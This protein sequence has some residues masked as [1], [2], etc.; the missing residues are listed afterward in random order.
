M[1]QESHQHP[2]RPRDP[3]VDIRIID[4][5]WEVYGECGWQGFTMDRVAKRARAG[6]AALYRRWP[7]K[8]SLLAAAIVDLGDTSA[9]DSGTLRGDLELLSQQLVSAYFGPHGR[10]LLRLGIESN[11]DPGFDGKYASTRRAQIVS[12]RNIVHRAAARGEVATQTSPT[13]V[14]DMLH[15][16][17]IS[18]LLSTPDDLIERTR[19][20]LP[21][22]ADGLV[23]L[24]VAAIASP[25]APKPDA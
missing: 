16:A 5:A 21:I 18:H 20:Q 13:L 6:K 2:G 25:A 10:A 22:F 8:S 19:A 12:A 17:I 7:D 24:I 9:I 11:A 4:A 1:N 3:C 23:S 14:I 15:G